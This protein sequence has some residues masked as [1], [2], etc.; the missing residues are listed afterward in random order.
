MKQKQWDN[1][2][3][4]TEKCTPLKPNAFPGIWCFPTFALNPQANPFKTRGL[5]LGSFPLLQGAEKKIIF[6]SDVPALHNK[7]IFRVQ[8]QRNEF[9]GG[10]CQPQVWAFFPKLKRK[11]KVAAVRE[12]CLSQKY[13]CR[14]QLLRKKKCNSPRHPPLSHRNW[15]WHS[16]IWPLD[17]YQLCDLGRANSCP[18][19]LPFVEI[20]FLF[21]FPYGRTSIW[22]AMYTNVCQV[23]GTE[24][25]L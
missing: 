17:S 11:W 18:F 2:H 23:P 15:R 4:A 16:G 1:W 21:F 22:E 25:D 7:H 10:L 19:S 12:Q 9:W 13:P 24:L 14:L 6:N 3:N 8:N 20:Q 5:C